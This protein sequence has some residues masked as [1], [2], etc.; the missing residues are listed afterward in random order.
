MSDTGRRPAPLILV[1]NE[2][3][4]GL[5]DWVT[6]TLRDRGAI[7]PADVDRLT[8]TDDV[9]RV[10]EVLAAAGERLELPGIGR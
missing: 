7:S 1:S 10:V 5:L 6:G 9:D 8:I 4:G 2:F 3:W